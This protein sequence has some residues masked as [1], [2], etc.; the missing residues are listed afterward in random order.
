MIAALRRRSRGFARNRRGTAA[1]EF[2][3]ILPIMLLVY[4]GTLEASALISMDRRVQ[5]IAG[6]VGDLVARADGSVTAAQLNDY[7]RASEAIMHPF[8]TNSL[9]QTVSLVRIDQNGN[10]AIVWSRRHAG[11]AANHTAGRGSGSPYTLP[12]E[13]TDIADGYVILSEAAYSYSPLMGVVFNE[14][15][16]LYRENFYLPRFGEEIR[17]N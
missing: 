11:G 3:L 15:F 16:N 10:T 13:I 2:A 17:L 12:R 6:S 7:F 5:T 4:L 8:S 1:V 9:I 14:Q